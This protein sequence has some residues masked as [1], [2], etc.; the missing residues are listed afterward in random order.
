MLLALC[1]VF[2]AVLP[3]KAQ[4]LPFQEDFKGIPRGTDRYGGTNGWVV[5]LTNS[6]IVQTN[7]VYGDWTEQL[8]ALT[9]IL[10]VEYR[11]V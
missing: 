7:V 2:L 9:K 5:T 4:N 11:Y 3:G 10:K 8:E 6:A 1:A